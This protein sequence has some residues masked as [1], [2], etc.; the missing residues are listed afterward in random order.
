MQNEDDDVEQDDSD[1]QQQVQLQHR[2]QQQEGNDVLLGVREDLHQEADV[3][4]IE[5][6]IEEI[7]I[8]E[9]RTG[10]SQRKNHKQRPETVLEIFKT[11]S[12]SIFDAE[13]DFEIS[14]S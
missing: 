4:G 14:F 12:S 10:C 13:V 5:L 1:A 9:S 2:R 3:S 7:T 6:Q 8:T 11:E